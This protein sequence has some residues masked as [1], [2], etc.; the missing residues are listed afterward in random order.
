MADFYDYYVKVINNDTQ[1]LIDKYGLLV[2]FYKLKKIFE[3]FIHFF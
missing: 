2:N 1:G 3:Y